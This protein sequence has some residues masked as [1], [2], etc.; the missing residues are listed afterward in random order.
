MIVPRGRQ[1][2]K[3]LTYVG[4]PL[5]VL[6][7]YDLAVVVAYKVLHWNWVALPHIP[8]ALFGSAIGIIVAFRNQSSYARWWEART[9]W[10][11]IINNSRS[12]ARQVTTVMMPLRE[13][14]AGELKETQRRLVYY[15]IAYA[16]ALRQQ[17][18]GLEPWA[19]LKP[20]LS[21]QEIEDLHGERNVPLAIQQWMGALLRQCQV[22]GWVD[23]AH[24]RALDANLDDIVDAQG[25][26]E[27]IKSTPMPK[28]YDYFPQLFVQMYCVMLPLTLVMSMGWFTP[29]GSTLVGFIFLALDKIGR[30]LE[31]PF[32][33]SIYDVPMTSLTT[34]IEINL[35]QLLGETELPKAIVPVNGVLW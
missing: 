17:L 13:A 26:T 23:I 14:E 6:V 22:R 4:M 16:H 30:D 1:L 15:Q 29:L 19:E 12:W 32:E 18:R 35:R 7:L 27:R 2:F 24:W 8:L 11:T 9:L 20:L 33:N 21:E 5:L 3:M 31:Y 34:T 25:G 10:G 28:Q